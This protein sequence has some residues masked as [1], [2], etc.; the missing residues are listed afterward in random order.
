MP[1]QVGSQI[2]HQNFQAILVE[3][4]LV[5]DEKRDCACYDT[6]DQ[7]FG[8]LSNCDFMTVMCGRPSIDFAAAWH[9][10]RRTSNQLHLPMEP[11]PDEGVTSVGKDQTIK[12]SRTMRRLSHGRKIEEPERTGHDISKT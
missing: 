8:Q 6:S 11:R 7:W 3:P 12:K 9:Y 2:S 4:R 10:Y 1:D 5:R